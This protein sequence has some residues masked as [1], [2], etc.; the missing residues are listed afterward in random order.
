MPSLLSYFN[1]LPT[2][3]KKTIIALMALSGVASAAW[4][5][6][7]ANGWI[8]KSGSSWVTNS[9]TITEDTTSKD[10]T[11]TFTNEDGETLDFSYSGRSCY[12]FAITLNLD[13]LTSP[14]T[15]TSAVWGG[16][17]VGFG[18]NNGLVTACIG[19]GNSSW[20]TTGLTLGSTG[21]LT[22]IV[23]TGEKGSM[24]L[25]YGEDDTYTSVTSSQTG[26][27]K[28]NGTTTDGGSYY[29]WTGLKESASITSFTIDSSIAT[30]VEKFA[31]WDSKNDTTSLDSAAMLANMDTVAAAM[32]V[33]PE[34]TTATLSLL[35]L[36]GLA[37]RRRRSSH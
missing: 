5:A 16:E 19:S 35:A 31:V 34:P 37:A 1:I 24:I 18:L 11:I 4:T 20:N 14:T 29:G 8:Y 3:M 36:V 12:T 27:N 22:L 2:I 10:L 25:A 26:N 17:K 9:A 13:D 21:S 7:D 6:D 33:I 28:A 32:K 15:A 30:A 23:T